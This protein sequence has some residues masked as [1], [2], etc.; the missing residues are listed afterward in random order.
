M[1]DKA[2]VHINLTYIIQE[3]R[4]AAVATDWNISVFAIDSKSTQI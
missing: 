1:Q 3:V 2:I 4:E